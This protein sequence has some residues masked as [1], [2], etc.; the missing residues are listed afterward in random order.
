LI[1]SDPNKNKIDTYYTDQSLRNVI[2]GPLESLGCTLKSLTHKKG[3][4]KNK[5]RCVVDSSSSS[6]CSD[7]SSSSSDSEEELKKAKKKQQVGFKES[8][9]TPATRSKAKKNEK[10]VKK[11]IKKK[12]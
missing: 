6:D 4:K 11:D 3:K 7:S 5:K 10:P 9:Q 2:H 12:K 1:I 8:K